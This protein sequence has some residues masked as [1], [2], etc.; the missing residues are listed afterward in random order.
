LCTAVQISEGQAQTTIRVRLKQAVLLTRSRKRVLN[1]IAATPGVTMSQIAREFGW[2]V[3]AIDYHLHL[4][5]QAGFVVRRRARGH[6][7]ALYLNGQ[8]PPAP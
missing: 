3:S 5:Q 8:A 2:H 1:V 4:L 6:K 7:Y